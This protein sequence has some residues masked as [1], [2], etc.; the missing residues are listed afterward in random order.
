MTPQVRAFH[1]LL[2]QALSEKDTDG[3]VWGNARFGCYAFYDLDGEVLYVGSASEGLRTRVRR[4]LTGHRTDAVATR[5][6]DVHEVAELELWPIWALEEV[7]RS[8]RLRV[9]NE[10]PGIESAIYRRAVA[11]N[12]FGPPL[13]EVTPADMNPA[14]LPPSRRFALLDESIR[15]ERSHPDARLARRAENLA[16]LASTVLERG[17][18]NDGMRRALLIQAARFTA[19]AATHLAYVRGLPKPYPAVLDIA[20]L[21]DSPEVD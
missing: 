8:D 16:R 18:A 14:T 20:G 1:V 15:Q 3:R 2:D 11:E 7:G 4:H 17:S 10:L 9:Q 12:Q 21:L 13:N 5:I 6:L 19:L